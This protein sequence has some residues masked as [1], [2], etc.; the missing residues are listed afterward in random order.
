[1]KTLYTL[2]ALFI[3]ISF[4]SQNFKE[5]TDY[6]LTDYSEVLNTTKVNYNKTFEISLIKDDEPL[7][8]LMTLSKNDLDVFL[9]T[10]VE[11][12]D[13]PNLNN[14]KKV[15]KVTFE[16]LDSCLKY[17]TYY[18]LITEE[19]LVIKLPQLTYRQCEY[20]T[21]KVEYIFPVQQFGKE[22]TIIQSLS[23][24]DENQVTDGIEIE[25]TM[26]WKEDNKEELYSS[27]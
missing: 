12:L 11:I 9:D 13:N 1:M 24:L 5:T 22:N 8:K 23:F 10:K 20:A 25:K 2:I 26:V 3:S 16:F 27:N 14:I 6:H 15:V 19:N 17:E 4:Y 7:A 21:E 18:F